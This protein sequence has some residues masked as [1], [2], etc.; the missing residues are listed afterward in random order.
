MG[1]LGCR[2]VTTAAPETSAGARSRLESPEEAQRTVSLLPGPDKQPLY[3]RGLRRD[4]QSIASGD[5]PSALQAEAT[6]VESAVGAMPGRRRSKAQR[7]TTIPASDG[8]QITSSA[9][10]VGS[11]VT[12][13]VA[14]AG[15]RR[16]RPIFY[17]E[18]MSRNQVCR[19][20]IYLNACVSACL[21][22]FWELPSDC[23][24][25]PFLFLSDNRARVV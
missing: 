14:A 20:V 4:S 23:R 12:V 15:P 9:A 16:L 7:R 11:A 24:F 2:K 10:T 22:L 5:A 3:P 6:K 1:R 25:R 8:D 18:Y 17:S 21:L 13:R 19:P